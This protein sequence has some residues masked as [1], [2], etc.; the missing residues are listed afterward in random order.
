MCHIVHLAEFK[1]MQFSVVFMGLYKSLLSLHIS[2]FKKNN[3]R[4]LL[5]MK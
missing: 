1:C 3:S 5:A 2:F 4:L